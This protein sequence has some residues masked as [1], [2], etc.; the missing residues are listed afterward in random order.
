MFRWLTA[1][2]VFAL[3]L[4]AGAYVLAGRASPPRL[5]IDKPEGKVVGQTGTLEI[6]VEA[7][8]P[9]LTALTVMLEQNGRV[10]PLFSLDRNDAEVLFGSDTNR[11]ALLDQ[12]NDS[13]VI[14][15]PVECD[16]GTGELPQWGRQRPVT[17]YVHPD[18]H[19][20]RGRD[21]QLH[22]LVGK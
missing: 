16:A 12:L 17:D 8:R 21:Q 5:T 9:R 20:G 13:A 3:L 15:S 4:F 1:F 7:P 2:V 18:S 6:T 11:S 19:V 10:T 22:S 14:Q